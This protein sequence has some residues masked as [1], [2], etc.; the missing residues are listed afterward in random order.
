MT[1]PVEAI[2]AGPKYHWFGYYDKFQFDAA[3]QRVLGMEVDFEGRS[4]RPGDEIG[5]GCIDLAAGRNWRRIGCSRAWGWQQGCML[6]WVPGQADRVLWND[7]EDGRFVCR[8]VD[9]ESGAERV[10]PMPVYALGPDGRT[11]VT[12][13][14]RR[15]NDTRPG[16]GYAGVPDPHGDDP[17]PEESGIWRLDLET[18][19]SRLILSLAE[20]ASIPYAHGDLRGAKHWFNHL[21]VGP[22]GKRFIFLHRWSWQGQ[23]FHTRMFT[24]DLDGGNLR[25]VDDSGATSHFIWRGEDHILMF[26]RPRDREWAF[27]LFDERDGTFETVLDDPN[28]GH[29]LYLP[30]SDWILNDTYPI[31][32]ERLQHLY[33]YHPGCDRRIELG[34]FPAP[35]AYQG[36]WRCDLHARPSRDG[37]LVCFDSAHGGEGRQLY[38]MDIGALNE[39][40]PV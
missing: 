13:D 36:E 12:T 32:G 17:A 21:L 10:L 30:D 24:A 18:G 25:V 7:C 22:T 37:R 31:G 29:C 5:I 2:T 11:A 1:L 14:F 23:G 6:Q 4:P 35:E 40:F 39:V 8:V 38:L 19:E 16:Y 15:I 9:L 27:Y 3:G 26:T 28:N 34:E 33:L 20:V